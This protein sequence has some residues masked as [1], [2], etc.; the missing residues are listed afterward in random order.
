MTR[1][2]VRINNIKRPLWDEMVA[3]QIV[4]ISLQTITRRVVRE[5]FSEASQFVQYAA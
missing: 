1:D 4:L 3:V 2:S 5:A